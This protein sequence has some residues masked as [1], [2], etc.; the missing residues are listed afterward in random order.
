MCWK[1]PQRYVSHHSACMISHLSS[2]RETSLHPGTFYPNNQLPLDFDL[3]VW[4]LEKNI[5]TYS[6]NGGEI[7]GDESHGFRIRR[8]SPTKQIQVDSFILSQTSFQRVFCPQKRPMAQTLLDLTQ[9]LDELNYCWWFRNPAITRWYPI[10]H[11]VLYIQTVVVN[12]I[13]EPW[14]VVL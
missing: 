5:R 11:R 4:W 6:P 7:H 8:K 12:G 10:I 9:K 1:Q 13:S 14:T 3:L 2:P